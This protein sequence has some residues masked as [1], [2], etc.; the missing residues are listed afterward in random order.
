MASV[1]NHHVR[2]ELKEEQGETDLKTV[3][4]VEWCPED[5]RQIGQGREKGKSRGDY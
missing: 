1:E 2:K 3:M 4:N 5:R